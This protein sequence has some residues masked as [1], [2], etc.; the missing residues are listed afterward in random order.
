MPNV[1]ICSY[2]EPELVERIAASA[3]G[4]AVRYRP[5][6]IP[7]PRFVADHS[8][9]PFARDADQRAEWSA[10]MREADVLF[11]FDY[12]DPKSLLSDGAGVRWVQAT[13]A[14]IGQFV[15]KHG[16]HR[17]GTTL[18]TAAGVHA[19][20][21]AEFV[22]W[23]MLAFAKGYPIARA[24]QREGRW[25]RFVGGELG[26]ATLAIVGLGSIGREVARMARAQGL[27]VI[28]TKR[29]TE[30]FTAEQVGVDELYAW[31]DL[32]A[33]IGVADYVCLIA[34]HTRETVGMMDAAAFAAMKRGSVLIN[35]GRGTLVQEQALMDALDHG[36]LAGA[37]LDVTPVEPLPE[38]HPLWSRDDVIVF[39]HSASTSVRENERL[40][41]LFLDN[42]QRF[43]GGAP[44]R[45]VYDP[46]RQY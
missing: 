35:I 17:P 11:D 2:L 12:T 15:E 42:L 22:L 44:L 25:K 38:G 27:R 32:H 3:A 23:G 33:M 20:P 13:S 39:P 9:H 29:T 5:D 18:T 16:L 37:V 10:L 31:R 19:K 30:G 7:A 26:E 45:N 46:E 28:G 6:L 8:G 14:G 21:L 4:V 40:T 24:Q 34:P 36:P 1:L 41:D 43:R